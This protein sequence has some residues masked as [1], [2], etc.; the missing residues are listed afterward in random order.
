M[1]KEDPNYPSNED[2]E[3]LLKNEE[4]IIRGYEDQ[5]EALK[6]RLKSLESEK[7]AS[8]YKNCYCYCT[9]LLEGSSKAPAPNPSTVSQIEN[10][11]SNLHMQLKAK[12][13][14]LKS[15]T[16]EITELAIED[17]ALALEE[18]QNLAESAKSKK[19]KQCS[20]RTDIESTL[21]NYEQFISNLP[22]EPDESKSDPCSQQAIDVLMQ[23]PC[24]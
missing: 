10:V 17:V 13:E 8:I 21:D 18:R 24:N 16:D 22:R 20:S 5:I 2:M 4:E 3:N 6:Q 11:I 14:L 19:C 7:N 9:S 12:D 23:S 15:Y 1:E